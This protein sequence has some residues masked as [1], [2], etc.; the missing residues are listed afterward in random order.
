MSHVRAE[1]PD[2]TLLAPGADPLVPDEAGLRELAAWRPEN[3]VLT[4]MA[5]M[6]PAAEGGRAAARTAIDSGLRH[7]EE[8]VHETGPRELWTAVRAA[9]E[10][11]AEAIEELTRPEG[12][13][14]GR[15]LLIPLDGGT[16]KV[17]AI[18]LPLPSEVA[19]GRV[20]RL[21]P[22]AAAWERGRP[23]AVAAA[24]QDGVELDLL[25][26]GVA[27]RLEAWELPREADP[28][29]RTGPAAASPAHGHHS[30]AAADRAQARVGDRLRRFLTEVSGKTGKALAPHRVAGMVVAGPAG[31]ADA[32]T[33]GLKLVY[34]TVGRT[35]HADLAGRPAPAQVEAL[36]GELE[37]LAE[38]RAAAAVQVVTDAVGA[39]TGAGGPGALPAAL[40]DGRV[41]NLV[42]DA[43][44]DTPGFVRP[45]GVLETLPLDGGV[46]VP[47]LFDEILAAALAADARFTVVSGPAAEGLA[48]HEGAAAVLRW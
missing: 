4:V 47:S 37:A 48:P 12:P 25:R 16:P 29:E 34:V 1:S 30:A 3:G 6:D 24:S 13:G 17:V 36:S 45:D 35:V 9:R 44:A 15:A 43:G 11:H 31:V 2:P 18:H 41:A 40:A 39:G 28:R 10:T 42:L 33:E 8:H 19:L 22:L 14:R 27:E 32:L 23:V 46:R 21:T 26:L 5:D 7:V 38:E 20:A